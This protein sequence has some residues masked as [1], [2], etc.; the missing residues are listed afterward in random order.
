MVTIYLADNGTIHRSG[1]NS[2][3]VLPELP[4]ERRSWQWQAKVT[5]LAILVAIAFALLIGFFLGLP[6]LTYAKD[7][8]NHVMGR[9]MK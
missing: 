7:W 2:R 5:A 8:H 6:L 3:D 4:T 1:F 9:P